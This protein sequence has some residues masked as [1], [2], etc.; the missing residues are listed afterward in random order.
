MRLGGDQIL[1]SDSSSASCLLAFRVKQ[2]SWSWEVSMNVSWLVLANTDWSWRTGKGSFGWR[3]VRGT[4]WRA[5]DFCIASL[6]FQRRS[7]SDVSLRRERSLSTDHRHL[8]ETNEE[9]AGN[10]RS[11]SLRLHLNRTAPCTSREQTWN[12]QLGMEDVLHHPTRFRISALIA[13]RWASAISN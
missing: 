1:G 4:Q 7:R 6:W 5:I 10:Y 3:W 11:V 8:P 2:Y 12:I 9:H 13:R